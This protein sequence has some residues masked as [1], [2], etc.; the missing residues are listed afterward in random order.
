M[1]IG[2]LDTTDLDEAAVTAVGSLEDMFREL[3]G[4]PAVEVVRFAVHRGEEPA[5]ADSC[6]GYIIPGSLS[7]ANDSEPWVERL[8]R[9][10]RRLRAREIPLVG[11]CFGHQL[12]GLAF[13]GVVAR[14]ESWE[15]GLSDVE[16]FEDAQGPELFAHFARSGSRLTRIYQVHREEVSVLPPGAVRL[17]GNAACR[18]QAFWL[19]GGV[20]GIQSHPE[21]TPSVARYFLERNDIGL[22]ADKKSVALKSLSAS[23]DHAVVGRLI[24]SFLAGAA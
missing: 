11:V 4:S 8:V 24:R 21:F 13:G 17:A 10:A 5:R 6:D 12:L 16:W 1:R 2:V 9:L 18:N 22:S 14:G 20:L 15:V 7:S 3:L 19:P 23:N